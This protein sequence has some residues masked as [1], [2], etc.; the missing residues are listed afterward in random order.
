MVIRL[1]RSCCQRSSRGIYGD[2]VQYHAKSGEPVKVLAEAMKKVKPT[3]LVGVAG[4]TKEV[5]QD[6]SSYNECPVIFALSNPTIK[7]K[8][9]LY[10]CTGEQAFIYSN[11]NMTG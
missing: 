11:V 4:I 2:K 10:E 3:V 7:A 6:I 9:V 8:N 5:I 1:Q